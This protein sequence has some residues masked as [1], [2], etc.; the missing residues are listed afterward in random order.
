MRHCGSRGG[1]FRR[2]DP[3][4]DAERQKR[5]CEILGPAQSPGGR[6]HAL[7]R[8]DDDLVSVYQA[9]HV[10]EAYLVKNLLAN[11]G[12]ESQVSEPNEPFSGL[13]VVAPDVLVRRRDEA[14]AR[15]VVAAYEETEIARAERPEWKCPVCGVTVPGAYDECDNCGADRPNAS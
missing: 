6:T 15:E 9:T 8:P 4:G 2:K 3:R 1:S 7:T 14:R 13:P 12:I 5:F 10:T 11:E